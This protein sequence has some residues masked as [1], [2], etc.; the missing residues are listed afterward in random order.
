MPRRA[1]RPG[2]RRTPDL[3]T[4]E[5]AEAL[6]ASDQP[7]Q[8]NRGVLLLPN[9]V[10]LA[11]LACGLSA[12]RYA[13]DGKDLLA[14]ALVGL[15]AVLDGLDG[16][17]ARML[18]ATSKMGAE[19]DSLCDAIGF[20]VTPAL[21]TYLIVV[22]PHGGMARDW[23]WVA[24]VVYA[25]CIVLRLARFNTLLDDPNRPPF[26]K[27]FFVGVPAPAAALLA[28]VPAITKV[29]F[30][31]GW[32]CSPIVTALWLITVAALAFS[33]LPTFSA[34]TAKVSRGRAP[35]LLLAAVVLLAALMSQ[36]LLTVLVIDLL[37]LLHIPYAISSYRWLAN[38]PDA[39]EVGGSERRAL[40]RTSRR[41]RLRI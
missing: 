35:I 41:R 39:W 22:R 7:G 29:Q 9:I 4:D 6:A 5:P 13:A 32:W 37:Y 19:L 12:V 3:T 10:T 14:L 30:G 40:R 17:L 24:V 15:A 8:R 11:A 28:L 33:R 25:A 38:H 26:T 36:P 18:S 27:E 34:K 21:I 23:C 2:S 31:D 1:N 20:G 16:R